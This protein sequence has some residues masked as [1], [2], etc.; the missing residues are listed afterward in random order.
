MY[1]YQENCPKPSYAEQIRT[2][3]QQTEVLIPP[4]L[5]THI[6]R[7]EGTR[8]RARP[9]THTRRESVRPPL[10]A[11][12]QRE[13]E[14]AR[15]RDQHSRSIPASSSLSLHTRAHTR[16]RAHAHTHTRTH[17]SLSFLLSTFFS[18]L[19]L[20]LLSLALCLPP[21]LP[22]PHTKTHAHTSA[23]TRIHTR[24]HYPAAGVRG[25]GFRVYGLGCPPTQEHMNTSSFTLHHIPY[26]LN[27]KSYNLNRVWQCRPATL[28]H[29]HTLTHYPEP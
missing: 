9:C 16:T 13:R 26:T 22:P 2:I 7:E 29:M 25:L 4:P 20:P 15:V 10:H 24:T 3:M 12:A 27:P 28:A 18:C 17:P 23:Y 8:A 5:H 14:R 19:F 21:S 11:H 1:I 6:Q